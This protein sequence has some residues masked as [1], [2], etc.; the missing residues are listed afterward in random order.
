L[1]IEHALR[2]KDAIESIMRMAF[3][4]PQTEFSL[5]E[6]AQG[7]NVSKS[8]ASRALQ[9]LALAG[10]VKITDL[11]VVWRISANRRSPVYIREKIVY[12][13]SLI[14]RSNLVDFLAA[15]FK[16][17]RALV[18]FGSFR[19][20]EDVKDSDIDIAVELDSFGETKTAELSKI[21]GLSQKQ[22]SDIV[23]V[24][25]VIG[26]K[27]V[28]TVFDR[29]NVDANL[30]NGIA[31]GIVL[32]G[33]LEAGKEAEREM[34]EKREGVEKITPFSQSAGREYG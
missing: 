1:R 17:P 29:K 10:L 25:K 3:T 23:N 31:N 2:E 9:Q 20:G 28:L 27:F 26:R 33:F 7:A 21:E 5:S 6:M 22:V 19:R 30:F 14:Y 18:L 4:Y 8:T 24:E 11:G 34:A 16:S 12:N 32:N 13:L 15:L